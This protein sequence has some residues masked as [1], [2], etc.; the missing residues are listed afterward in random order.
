MPKGRVGGYTYSLQKELRVR[1]GGPS[2]HREELVKQWRTL[3]SQEG[4]GHTVKD[5]GL[6][7][8]P[9]LLP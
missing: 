5:L 3:S 9:V 6:Q 4:L 7:D 8:L 1:S 2:P